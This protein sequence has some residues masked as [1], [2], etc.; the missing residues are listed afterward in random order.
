MLQTQTPEARRDQ[1]YSIRA[2]AAAADKAKPL[3]TENNNGDDDR[4]A[5]SNHYASF[6]KGL[7]HD[8]SGEVDR[9]AYSLLLK[10]LG[11]GLPAD[12]DAI[13]LGLGR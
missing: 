10:A 5:T 6:S 3:P 13:S 9:A 11:S 4:Y 2:G 1:A 8:S 7:P 12:F